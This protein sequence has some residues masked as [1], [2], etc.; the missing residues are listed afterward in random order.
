MSLIA[1][2]PLLLKL[3]DVAAGDPGIDVV[4]L[5]V[6]HQLDLLHDPRDRIDGRVD[7]DDDALAQAAGGLGCSA[8]HFELAIGLEFG[9]QTGHLGGADV[10]TDDQILV[11]L[12]HCLPLLVCCAAL[13]RTAKPLG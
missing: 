8:Q 7:I 10:Q 5:A 9:H 4:N 1:T 3:R 2:I 6:G 13:I 11:F 12:A